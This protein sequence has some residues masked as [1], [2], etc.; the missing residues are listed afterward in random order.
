MTFSMS[1]PKDFEL[2][3]QDRIGRQ[4]NS[5]K[6]YDIINGGTPWAKMGQDGAGGTPFRSGAATRG[7]AREVIR[8]QIRGWR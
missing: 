4:S 3:N 8:R 7:R 5:L 2:D 1:L 6:L